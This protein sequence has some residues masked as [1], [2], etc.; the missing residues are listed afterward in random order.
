LYL[1]FWLFNGLHLGRT[2]QIRTPT[3][4]RLPTI[5]LVQLLR[6]LVLL[7]LS[8]STRGPA[9]KERCE[10]S[11]SFVLHLQGYRPVSFKED[12]RAKSRKL[13]DMGPSRSS[14]PKTP[15]N[16]AWLHLSLVEKSELL[17]STLCNCSSTVPATMLGPGQTSSD[18]YTAGACQRTTRP[19]SRNGG[20]STT[21]KPIGG[22]RS[23]SLRAIEGQLC[24]LY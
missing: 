6:S 3:N 5:S 19:K 13:I 23:I 17:V 10:I 14:L 2:K 12:A 20:W 21:S 9:P 7:C 1:G 24:F 11:T 16:L 18:N 15:S 4:L 22:Q 8:I